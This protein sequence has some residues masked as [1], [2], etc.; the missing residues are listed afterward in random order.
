MNKHDA[1]IQDWRCSQLRT[2]SLAARLSR[3][4]RDLDGRTGTERT[5]NLVNKNEPDRQETSVDQTEKENDSMR[6][7]KGETRP[8]SHD[9]LRSAREKLTANGK[10][11]QRKT[12]AR[13][14][15]D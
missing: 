8:K 12:G 10:I 9:L 15:S 13:K 4:T 1:R 2:A 6:E 11:R 5:K 7:T 3:K 14:N